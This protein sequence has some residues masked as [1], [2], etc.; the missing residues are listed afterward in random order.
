MVMIQNTDSALFSFLVNRMPN[1]SEEF[2]WGHVEVLFADSGKSGGRIKSAMTTP[3]RHIGITSGIS[4]EIKV[5]GFQDNSG[6]M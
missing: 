4:V 5:Y 6:V 2:L 3:C 1:L